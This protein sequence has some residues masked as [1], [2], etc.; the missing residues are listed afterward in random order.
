MT[1]DAKQIHI[2]VWTGFKLFQTALDYGRVH[3]SMGK[4]APGLLLKQA[5]HIS[6]APSWRSCLN[7]GRVMTVLISLLQVIW[8][9]KDLMQLFYSLY[10]LLHHYIWSYPLITSCSL[11]HIM[12]SSSYN[13]TYATANYSLHFNG[14]FD[15]THLPVC[16]NSHTCMCNL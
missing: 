10:K 11:M 9:A 15:S 1:K 14:Y 8:Y 7:M 6:E 4:I 16:I 13:H 2:R 3:I 5:R 12:L